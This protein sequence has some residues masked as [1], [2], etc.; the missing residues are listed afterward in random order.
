M[1]RYDQK[2]NIPKNNEILEK[3]VKNMH[4]FLLCTDSI[5]II[6]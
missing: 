6:F 4:F 5:N 1:Q 2:L 3:P